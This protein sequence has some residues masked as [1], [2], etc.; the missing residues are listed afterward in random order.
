MVI[1][2]LSVVIASDLNRYRPLVRVSG[3][4]ITLLGIV[5]TGVDLATTTN[6]WR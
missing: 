5:F 1:G 4:C 3:L 2:A 6:R